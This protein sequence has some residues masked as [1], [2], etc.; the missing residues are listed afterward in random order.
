MPEK[1]DTYA[2]LYKYMQEYLK[3]FFG[4]RPLETEYEGQLF[5]RQQQLLEERRKRMLSRVMSRLAAQ[6]IQAS[7][8]GAQFVTE[9]VEEPV[10]QAEAQLDWERLQRMEGERLRRETLALGAAS[11]KLA[12]EEAERQRRSAFW[13]KLAGGVL[14]GGITGFMTGGPWGALAGAGI[15]L[16]GGIAGDGGAATTTVGADYQAMY[17]Q[18]VQ[19]YL[20]RLSQGQPYGVTGV[21]AGSAGVG[22]IGYGGVGG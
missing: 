20:R 10:A 13:G 17:M 8:V 16:A 19:D 3:Q 4:D 9:Q 12:E 7:G 14:K 6:G 22:A 18:L 21:G 1:S 11:R 5:T 15:G 2:D